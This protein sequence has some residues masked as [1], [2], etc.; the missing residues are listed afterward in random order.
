MNKRINLNEEYFP[1]MTIDLFATRMT[2]QPPQLESRPM[3]RSHQCI[4]TTVGTRTQHCPM[5]PGRGQGTSDFNNTST[6]DTA[7]VLYP[8]IGL[9]LSNPA[10]SPSDSTDASNSPSDPRRQGAAGCLAYI[11][12]SCKAENLSEQAS[13]LLLPSWRVLTQCTLLPSWSHNALFHKWE[14]WCQQW[15]I[16]PISGHVTL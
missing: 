3:C 4:H 9:T 16:N 1:L 2:I 13:E 10:T 8:V 5:G 15:D 7:L 6:E 11:R 12:N 14:C